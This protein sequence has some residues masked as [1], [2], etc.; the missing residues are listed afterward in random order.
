MRTLIYTTTFS[1]L[2]INACPTIG[3]EITTARVGNPGN[4]ADFRYESA[5]V[6]S[7]NYAFRMSRT[8]ITNA[9]YAEFLNAVASDDPHFLYNSKMGD[10]AV[11]GIDRSGAAGSFIYT[12]KPPA[13]GQERGGGDYHYEN[14]PVAFVDWYDAIRFANW[15]HNGQGNGDT[16][17]GAYVLFGGSDVPTNA[18]EITRQAGARWWLPSEDEWY[19]SA[20]YD[21]TTGTYFDF[22]T[23][24]N[25]SPDN[26]V[27]SADSGNST[28]LEI[29]LAF[30]NYP[31][32]DVGAYT[33]SP[34]PFGTF[35]QAGNVA[36]W[37]ETL[38]GDSR[39]LRGGSWQGPFEA[40]GADKSYPTLP[41]YNASA[42]VGFR[43]A[44]VV[45][46]PTSV[47]LL[48]SLF[49]MSI[50]KWR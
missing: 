34:G 29:S 5:G 22:P 46:E 44:T 39:G 45:P 49:A 50:C 20:Y 35:D 26:N 32:T 16:E 43:L 41:L 31:F 37:N 8:E 30:S 36:E 21:P 4:V 23:R 33:V 28:N 6:G 47:V 17:S 25:S 38:F 48:L 1:L 15:M 42:D 18:G 9:Q 24:S 27:P 40:G 12:V 13:S 10:F 3:V 2:Y 11:G 19:K 7:V 14:K